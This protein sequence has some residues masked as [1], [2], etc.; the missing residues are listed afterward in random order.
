MMTRTFAALAALALGAGC[1]SRG[2]TPTTTPGESTAG[3][4]P[5]RPGPITPSVVLPAN[6]EPAVSLAAWFQVGS[7]DDPVG[8]E[9]LAW[10][11]AQMVA[12]AATQD[13][14]YDQILARLYPMAADYGI[15]VDTEMTVLSGRAPR[16]KA[17]E[18]LALFT[19]AYTK[20]AFDTADFER[21]RAEALSYVEKNLRYALDEELG[22]AAFVDA[23]FAGT[24]YA[25]PPPGH[26]R[27]R[28]RRSRS[29]TCAS[30]GAI[31]TRRTGWC[32]V[33]PAAGR[34][35]CAR[36]SRARAHS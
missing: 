13:N 6:D 23:L 19:A 31:T 1:S 24:S 28:S 18:Y 35:T 21:L 22:K 33:W 4:Q 15:T 17:S 25:H 20:P 34:R 27:R 5:A 9:G 14:A 11:T 2:Q 36:G 7:G 30:S 26:R 12:R 8:K 16:D 32:S 29:R 3:A 10:L